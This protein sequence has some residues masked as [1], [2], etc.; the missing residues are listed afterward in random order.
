[1]NIEMACFDLLLLLCFVFTLRGVAWRGVA[2]RGVAWR[3]MAWHGIAFSL[4]M[5][6]KQRNL[7][8]SWKRKN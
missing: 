6:K 4:I 7:A 2:W 5:K 3:G 1:M 8:Y